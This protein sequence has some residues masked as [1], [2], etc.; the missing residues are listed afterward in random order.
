MSNQDFRIVELFSGNVR[1]DEVTPADQQRL[2]TFSNRL[3]K[4]MPGWSELLPADSPLRK[5]FQDEALEAASR[6]EDKIASAA[7]DKDWD[8]VRVLSEHLAD[9]LVG[10]FG[11]SHDRTL[12]A[13][14]SCCEWLANQIGEPEKALERALQVVLDVH[15]SDDPNHETIPSFCLIIGQIQA[16][17][18]SPNEALPILN[19]GI[20]VA[21][22]LGQHDKL[23]SLIELR[24]GF[25]AP[26]QQTATGPSEPEPATTSD[27]RPGSTTHGM[28]LNNVSHVMPRPK[29]SLE[30]LLGSL[31]QDLDELLDATVLAAA[32]PVQQWSSFVLQELKPVCESTGESGAEIWQLLHD[33]ATRSDADN[34]ATAVMFFSSVFSQFRDAP[35]KDLVLLVAATVDLLSQHE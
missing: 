11:P 35:I 34:V 6:L 21:L 9:R 24:S 30:D 4:M 13:Q 32:T 19:Q 10:D 5:R 16:R 33:R 27:L 2:R 26:T 3:D 22:T 1:P 18:G 12:N 15:D 25:V 23:E 7:K 31:T 20:A 14:L 29:D 17:R 28:L 8:T